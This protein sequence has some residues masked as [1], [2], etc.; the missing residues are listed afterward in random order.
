MNIKQGNYLVLFALAVLFASCNKDFTKTECGF[1]ADVDSVNIEVQFYSPEIVRILKSKSDF[2][3]EKK[4]IAVVKTP[5]PVAFSVS[6]QGK[7]VRA[8]TEKM[9]VKLDV[10]SGTLS[11]YNPD[12][13]ELVTELKDGVVFTPKQDLGT[14]TFGV[15]QSFVLDNDECIYGLGQFQKGKMS[16]RNQRLRMEQTNQE[17]VVPFMVSNKGYGVYWD[18]YSITEFTDST[19]ATTFDSE[20]GDCIDYYFM[21][22]ESADGVISN[23]RELTGRVP[24]MPYWTFGYWQSKERYKSQDELVG[25]VRKYRDMKVPIDG[26]I[27][28]WQ[29]WG[30]NE[31]W[32]AMEFLNPEFPNPQK[33]I[34]DVHDLN[35]HTIISCWASFGPQTKQYEIFNRNEMSMDFTT[36][37]PKAEVYDAYSPK[38]R[39]IYWDFLDKGIFSLGMDGWWLDASEPEHL[40]VKDEDYNMAPK[41]RGLRRI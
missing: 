34:Y 23:M 8:S 41:G 38:A 36:W 10:N 27:Q 2:E 22:G 31:H 32:N 19:E 5:A 13:S 37:P 25:V 1:K 15:K 3:F 33:M 7:I 12:G 11:F 4:S 30:D 29:Y 17:T 6:S 35:A 24:M 21:T 28:D 14:P 39:D 40:S 18:N 26:I 9:V 16:Q 20:I